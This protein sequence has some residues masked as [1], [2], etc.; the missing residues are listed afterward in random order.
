MDCG[1]SLGHRVSE[2]LDFFRTDTMD[3]RDLHAALVNYRPYETLQEDNHTFTV[4]VQ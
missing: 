2:D 4:I 3:V 1:R